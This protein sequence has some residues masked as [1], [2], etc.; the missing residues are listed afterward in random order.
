MHG[1]FHCAFTGT[2]IP[3]Q[4][5]FLVREGNAR[6]LDRVAVN[7]VWLVIWMQAGRLGRSSPLTEVN[8][9]FFSFCSNWSVPPV[10]RFLKFIANF[11]I[12]ISCQ[13]HQRFNSCSSLASAIL[14]AQCTS[15]C[16]SDNL[17][18]QQAAQTSST[19]AVE[20]RLGFGLQVSDFLI[21]FFFKHL[22]T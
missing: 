2:Q 8:A 7:A 17:N 10:F 4:Y 5:W 14:I 16:N 19:A 13:T 3:I 11:K 9:S 12:K 1:L 22:F 15:R 20:L 21:F 6:S 18:T